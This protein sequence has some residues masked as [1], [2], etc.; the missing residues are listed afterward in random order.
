MGEIGHNN[1][2]ASRS[3]VHFAERQESCGKDIERAFGMLQSRFAIIQ[4]MLLPRLKNK[5]ER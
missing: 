4:H 5:Y 3:E 2:H 1:T